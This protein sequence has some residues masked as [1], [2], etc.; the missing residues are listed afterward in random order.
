MRTLHVASTIVLV[1]AMPQAQ[2][3]TLIA[4]GAT[5]KRIATGFGFV[6]GP[7]ANADGTVY[8][9]DIPNQRIHR[10]T[11]TQGVSTFLEESGR[12]NGLRFDLDGNLLVCEMGNRRVTGINPQG[13]AFVLADHF[14]G[15][16]FNSP[17]DLW[18]DPK[19]GVYFSD[20][21]MGPLTTRRSPDI[22]CTTSRRTG[23]RSGA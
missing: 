2:E 8:F 23:A 13:E 18:V 6:E 16:R 4:P 17:N 9:T 21:P 20:P 19:G 1:L 3:T 14:E 12:A 15:R 7:A 5:V 10:W 11:P 22:T